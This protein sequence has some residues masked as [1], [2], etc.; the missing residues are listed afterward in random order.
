MPEIANK[1]SSVSLIHAKNVIKAT[2]RITNGKKTTIK[3]I[4]TE[5]KLKLRSVES[6]L[7]ES[8]MSKKQISHLRV[9]IKKQYK[10]KD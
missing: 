8:A 2:A 10:F 7:V 3:K 9:S 4:K 6:L 1:D 5:Q